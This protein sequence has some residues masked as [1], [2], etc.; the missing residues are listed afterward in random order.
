M[1]ASSGSWSQIE[2]AGHGCEIYE[3]GV[4]NEHG[5]VVIYLHGVHLQRLGEH[6]SFTDCFDRHGLRVIA[7]QTKR[8]WWTNRICAEFDPEMTAERFV[9]DPVMSEIRQRW[10]PA[11]T[12]IALLGTS[13]GGQGALRFS[14]KYPHLFPVVAAISPAIDYQR[15]WE[16]GDE[17]L[18]LMYADPESARQDTATLHVHPLNWPRHIW[19]CCDPTDEKWIESSERLQMKLSA[20]GIPHKCDLETIA[21]GHGFDYYD[22]MAPAAIDHIAFALDRERLRVV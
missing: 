11:P 2:I 9:L 6:P 20:L 18:P 5:Y 3:P 17:T 10:D 1:D 19:F 22:V 13:M 21:G 14:F 12:R 16:D 4:P 8:S 15:R 7:P